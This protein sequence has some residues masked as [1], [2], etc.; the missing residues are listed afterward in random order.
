MTGAQAS[1]LAL[2][3]VIVLACQGHRLAKYFRTSCSMQPGRLRSSQCAP[4]VAFQSVAFQ[5]HATHS[6]PYLISMRRMRTPARS[7]TTAVTISNPG[8]EIH[9][10]VGSATTAKGPSEIGTGTSEFK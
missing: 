6:L 2:P 8:T 3:E 9:A 10:G 7:I 5:S 4:V 1:S